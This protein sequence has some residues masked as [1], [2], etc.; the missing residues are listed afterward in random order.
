MSTLLSNPDR[1]QPIN[2][3]QKTGKY[4]KTTYVD[5]YTDSRNI[6]EGIL[7]CC[8]RVQG[9]YS[10]DGFLWT[11][12]RE[13]PNC[14]NIAPYCN[15]TMSYGEKIV[16]RIL[17]NA[18][19]EFIPHYSTDWSQHKV[20]DFYIPARRMIIEA[21][22]F[23]GVESKTTVTTICRTKSHRYKQ[24]FIYYEDDYNKLINNKNMEVA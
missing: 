14:D 24:Y 22:E 19:I 11:F 5:E 9:A 7:E 6:K 15:D 18:G 4:I 20:Y 3:Y 2:Q 10:S 1:Y 16:Y 12:L 13:N 23:L 8:Q 17:R 21:T